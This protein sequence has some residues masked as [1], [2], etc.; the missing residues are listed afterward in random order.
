MSKL[1]KI[2]IYS[3]NE[4]LN[5]LYTAAKQLSDEVSSFFI[6]S[7]ENIKG[8]D[9]VYYL[10]D[11]GNGKNYESY[12][13]VIISAIKVLQPDA[14]LFSTSVRCRM[15]AA[16]V[17]ASFGSSVLSDVSELCAVDRKLVAKRMVYGGSAIKT[18]RSVDLAVACIS[19]GIFPFSELPQN[20]NIEEYK[21]DCSGGIVC[22]G[23]IA[24]KKEG[25]D[26]SS[27]KKVVC[28]GRGCSS[29]SARKAAAEFAALTGCE[30]GCTRPVTE[31]GLMS[32]S[33]YVG[34]SGV[35]LKP[36]VYFGFGIS[37]QIQHQVGINTSR[38]IFVVNKDEKALFFKD[39]DYGLVG[40]VETVLP[41]LIS[42]LKG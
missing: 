10:G 38:L 21:A 33:Q 3:D 41:K 1:N 32:A 20:P 34:I 30:M 11:V 14:I 31:D 26:L 12:L 6:G 17:A 39:A 23:V 4:Q 19:G 9:T 15:M 40:D 7:R 28:I 5:M 8:A 35:M 16:V 36:D 13:P 42:T 18:E 27:A 37:G 2:I 24:K 29:D 25:V 22:T